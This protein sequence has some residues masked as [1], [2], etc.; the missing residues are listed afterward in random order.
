MKYEMKKPMIV[1]YRYLFWFVCFFTGAFIGNSFVRADYE[2]IKQ[3]QEPLVCWKVD[4]L[5]KRTGEPVKLLWN[6]F[7]TFDENGRMVFLKL[8]EGLHKV[9]TK[10][11]VCLPEGASTL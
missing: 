8:N 11:W 10:G 7:L 3:W 6:N 9:P 1:K 2:Y 4:V 5:G